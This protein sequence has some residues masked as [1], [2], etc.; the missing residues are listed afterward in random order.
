MMSG[1]YIA[2]ANAPEPDTDRITS[3]PRSFP[4]RT[5]VSIC[6]IARA[7]RAAGRTHSRA[8]SDS[9]R[10]ARPRTAAAHSARS[11]SGASGRLRLRR[12]ERGARAD[13]ADVHQLLEQAPRVGVRE[14]AAAV[15]EVADQAPDPACVACG[16][17]LLYLLGLDALGEPGLRAVAACGNSHARDEMRRVLHRVVLRHRGLLPVVISG[18]PPGWRRYRI[19][20]EE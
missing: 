3:E 16:Q 19:R 8:S 1:P 11:I 7:S 17:Q 9:A 6:R 18:P 13:H 15:L 10:S 2:S 20:K 12:C 14:G 5:G 4:D